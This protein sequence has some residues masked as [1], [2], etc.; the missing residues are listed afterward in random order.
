MHCADLVVSRTGSVWDRRSII[1]LLFID[2]TS[3]GV[4]TGSLNHRNSIKHL[5]CIALI[6]LSVKLAQFGIPAL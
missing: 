5:L 2:L 6:L 4:E 3:F 1:H